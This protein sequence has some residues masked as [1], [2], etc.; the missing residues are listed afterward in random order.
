MIKY[1]LTIMM[2]GLLLL[3]CEEDTIREIADQ[4]TIEYNIIE[5]ANGIY[6]IKNKDLS[7][8]EVEGENYEAVYYNGD[9]IIRVE[10]YD[11]DGKLTDDFFVAA[12]TSLEYDDSSRVKYLRYFDKDGKRWEDNTFGYWSIEYI[13]DEN[14]Q[15]RMEIYRDAE[16]K[17][18]EVPRDNKGNIAK[19]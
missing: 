11:K 6:V 4:T 18:L 2:L 14:N 9:N 10:R 3:G 12:V 8:S 1:T 16:S 7:K 17:F 5:P 13:Y 15:V 19:V